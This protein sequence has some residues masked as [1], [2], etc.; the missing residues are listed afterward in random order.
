MEIAIKLKGNPTESHCSLSSTINPCNFLNTKQEKCKL[1]NEN[2][3]YDFFE[4]AYARCWN[5]LENELSELEESD[6][7]D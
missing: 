4:H 2:L 3:S 5:C 1:F 6:E 7:N